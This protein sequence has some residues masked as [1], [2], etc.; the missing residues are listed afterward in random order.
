L[1]FT[2]GEDKIVITDASLET[3][4]FSVSAG[5]PPTLTYNSA[6]VAGS[7]PLNYYP[8]PPGDFVAKAAAGG[9]V[10]LTY[11]LH[12]PVP[13]AANDFNGDGCSDI[14]W[15][16]DDGTVRDWLGQ[17]P[18]GNF[19]DNIDNVNILSDWSWHAVGTGDFNGDGCV[20]ILW[21]NDNGTVRDWLG[22]TDGTFK[23]NIDKVNI[24]SDWSWQA[25][26]T[27]DF[28]GDGYDDILWQND[29]GT[30][31]QWLG[32]SD[33]SFLGNIA[34]VNF[35]PPAG[36]HLV[37]TGDFNG[38]GRSDILWQSDAGIVTDW[39]GKLDGSFIDNSS[40]ANIEIATTWRVVGTGDFNGDKYDDILWRND[41]GTIREWL[42]QDG[43]AFVDNVAHVNFIPAV[44]AQVIG[45]G[46]Y[47]GDGR[48]DLLW[49]N[50][51]TVT[52]SLGQLD[53]SFADNSAYVNITTGTQWHA[54]DPS[55]HQFLDPGLGA[56]D[57]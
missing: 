6:G 37:G 24:L 8:L 48:A 33:G 11:Q 34:H 16:H 15:K 23:G 17:R 55:V 41:D 44:G 7:V 46:D 53:G 50:N 32:Q 4:T 56:W 42:G 43:G 38:D 13:H 1:D 39:L 31:R 10:E 3:F 9:G 26:G 30:V 49:S 35:I 22:Q 20:D 29:N 28:N 12:V 14:L 27:G 52:Q 36:M 57:Y 21:K 2:A 40:K 54:Q 45:I 25:V 18:N 5:F 19:V 47:N 51:G